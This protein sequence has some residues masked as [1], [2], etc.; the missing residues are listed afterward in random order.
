MFSRYFSLAIRQL[1]KNKRNTIINIIGLS[2]GFATALF[3]LLH[4]NLELSYDNY[5]ADTDRIYRVTVNQLNGKVTKA[6]STTI[7][8][9]GPAISEEIPQVEY[10]ARIERS[11]PLKVKYNDKIFNEKCIDGADQNIFSI[12]KIPFLNGNTGYA[13]TKPGTGVITHQI[14][15]KYFG[16]ESPLGKT[17]FIEK[18]PIEI[19]GV[20][21]DSPVNTHYKFGIITSLAGADSDTMHRGWGADGLSHT[22]IKLKPGTEKT[23]VQNLIQKLADNHIYDWMLKAGI[24]NKYL[25][26]PIRSIHF[27]SGLE[28]EVEPPGNSVY[29]YIFAAAGILILALACMNFI[30]LSTA[31]FSTRTKEVGIRKVIGAQR[32]QLIRQFM[33]ESILVSFLALMLAMLIISSTYPAL[34]DYLNTDIS[35]KQILQPHVLFY[36]ILLF[37][38]VGVFSG[39]YPAL[40]LSSFN[41]S[42]IL[43]NMVSARP[44]TDVLRKT[45]VVVQFTITI[46]LSV[47]SFII[48]QQLNFMKDKKLG[49][50]KDHK[51]VLHIPLARNAVFEDIL[52]DSKLIGKSEVVKNEF[53]KHPAIKGVTIS[54]IIPGEQINPWVI[55]PKGARN[56]SIPIRIIGA[57]YDF[58]ELYKIEQK[59]SLG[60]ARGF[61]DKDPWGRFC[62][63]LNE[64]AAKALGFD[65]PEQIIGKKFYENEIPVAGIIKDFNFEGVQRKITP[66][67]IRVFTE[68]NGNYLTLDIKTKEMNNV[69]NYVKATFNKFFPGEMFDY[70]FLG[71]LFNRQYRFEEQ[72]NKT[73]TLFTIVGFSIGILGLIGLTAFTVERRTKE[74]GIRK[75]LGAT[76]GNIFYLLSKEYLRWILLSNIIAWPIAYFFINRWLDS[77]AY[78]INVSIFT[79]IATG[80]IAL[81]VAMITV[82]SYTVKAANSNPV[83]SLKCE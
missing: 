31:R 42:S 15:Q 65:P 54:T 11:A 71:E 30:N 83:K 81:I 79:F 25:L 5:H 53:K 12:L 48:L 66:L 76:A 82:S 29:L 75:V 70:F 16:S 40:F 77:F 62:L 49:F 36:I 24:K 27:A 17:I 73:F 13:L 50:E 64:S 19:T 21:K 10:V 72:V 60:L 45:L 41:I 63:Y 33:G 39:I 3:I 67:C 20:I 51:M 26:E 56:K 57:D 78:R 58:L 69:I 55:W 44:N 32:S 2:L 7:E 6:Y 46:I 1:T 80:V 18:K 43:R 8:A 34:N 74:I 35:I 47:F 14:A 23:Q 4:I 22:Y 59:A 61:F 37:S 38:I 68:S 9:L 28:R 52:T